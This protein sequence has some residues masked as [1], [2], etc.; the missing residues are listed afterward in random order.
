MRSRKPV[1]ALLAVAVGGVALIAIP[2]WADAQ[3]FQIETASVGLSSAVA[4]NGVALADYDNDGDIDIYFVSRAPNHPNNYSGPNRLFRNNGD[5]SFTDVALEAGLQGVFTDSVFMNLGAAWGD[6]DNDGD[7][8]IYLTNKGPNQLYENLGDGTFVGVTEAAGVAAGPREST[9]AVWFDYDLDGDLDLYVSNFGSTFGILDGR[10]L[11]YRNNGDGTFTNVT[12]EAGVSDDGYAWTTMAFD[13]NADRYPD[14]YVVND[15]GANHFYLNNGDGTFREATSE[16]GLEDAGHS[17]GVTV[18]D[19]DGDGKLD[20]YVTNIADE[21]TPEP[22]PLFHNVG[23]RR[24]ED[25]AQEAGVQ[26]AGWGWGTE[27][28][29]YDLD[30]DLDLYVVNGFTGVQDHNY[31]YENNGDGTFSERSAELG[32]GNWAEARGMAVFDGDGDGRLDVFVSNWRQGA[33]FYRN[34]TSGNHYLLVEL[35]GSVSNR[36]ARGAIVY[37]R[38]GGLSLARAN[39]GVEFLGQSKTP[40]H[41]GLGS[42]QTVNEL[43]VAWPSGMVRTFTGIGAD[44]TVVIHET[45]GIITSV[46]DKAD[47]QT[48]IPDTFVLYPNYPNPFNGGT[49]LRFSVPRSATIQLT[50]HNIRG[51]LVR[52]LFSGSVTAGEHDYTWDGRN[53]VGEPAPSGVYLYRVTVGRDVYTGKMLLVR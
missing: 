28:F 30:G 24:Y 48:R 43:T 2:R 35:V 31:F 8:D 9:S 52:R 19:Y 34:Q 4:G 23:Y 47:R 6:Y 29:D 22:N 33:T 11:L 15:Y 26:I 1:V 49:K 37:L 41:F 45:E 12:D 51:E 21:D 20:L 13:A 5:G 38:A 16:Y 25:R 7:M 42:H 53:G 10:N 39:D 14:L 36:D 40:I 17:M 46:E 32:L 44:Q 3:G 18:G 50:I 27:F